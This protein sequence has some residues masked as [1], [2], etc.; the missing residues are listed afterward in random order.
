MALINWQVF[1]CRRRE[2]FFACVYF[3]SEVERR[4]IRFLATEEMFT[5][6][7]ARVCVK[8]GLEVVGGLVSVLRH[9]FPV[10]NPILLPS[11]SVWKQNYR[12]INVRRDH[13][14]HQAQPQVPQMTAYSKSPQNTGKQNPSTELNNCL[15]CTGAKFKFQR[16]IAWI[17]P[18]VFFKSCLFF[19]RLLHRTG[20]QTHSKRSHLLFEHCDLWQATQLLCNLF[21]PLI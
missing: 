19:K 16:R 8:F 18:W 1:N 4:R 3:V 10:F 7:W 6:L 20:N 13:Q 12:I 15:H 2:G 5:V 17:S 9:A 11:I 14:D 21:S